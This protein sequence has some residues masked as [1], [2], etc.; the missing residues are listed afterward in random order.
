MP[1]DTVGRDLIAWIVDE[2]RD[3]EAEYERT[4][5]A[6]IDR[7]LDILEAIRTRCER[8]LKRANQVHERAVADGQ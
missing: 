3:F 8:D 2:I 6:G 5:Y 4:G 1:T 7:V